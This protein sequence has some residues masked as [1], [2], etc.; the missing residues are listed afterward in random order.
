M[1]RVVELAWKVKKKSNLMIDYPTCSG[2]GKIMD[3]E[4]LM[5]NRKICKDCQYKEKID[6]AG[7]G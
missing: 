7:L 5:T 3:E 1:K 2:C 4:D 6:N